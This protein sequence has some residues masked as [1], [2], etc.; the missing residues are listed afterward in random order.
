M[1]ATW[2]V[3]WT[4]HAHKSNLAHSTQT[5]KWLELSCSKS[6][7]FVWVRMWKRV[8]AV[9]AMIHGGTE[10]ATYQPEE[11]Q[12]L[13]ESSSLI[14]TL[15]RKHTHTHNY[16]P[17]RTHTPQEYW[18]SHPL[19]QARASLLVYLLHLVGRRWTRWKTWPRPVLHPS[20]LLPEWCRQWWR[21]GLS[22]GTPGWS[23]TRSAPIG[24]TSH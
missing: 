10:T 2:A 11:W 19:S 20:V 7:F 16:T 8:S 21:W 9:W 14:F 3:T 22:A 15:P 1:I 23:W 17:T 13:H 24:L 18:L 12:R 6:D 4:C 5:V